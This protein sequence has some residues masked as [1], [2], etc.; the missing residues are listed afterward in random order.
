MKKFND[1]KHRKE[2]VLPFLQ[3]SFVDFAESGSVCV[4]VSFRS[5]KKRGCYYCFLRDE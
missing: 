2:K 5:V 1:M 3:Q 4:A